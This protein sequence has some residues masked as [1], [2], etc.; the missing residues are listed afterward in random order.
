MIS[1]PSIKEPNH[2]KNNSLIKS[3]DYFNV[4]P[5]K[6]HYNYFSIKI[7][8]SSLEKLSS[9]NDERY[10]YFLHYCYIRRIE[11]NGDI[12]Y[13]E[14][15]QMPKNIIIYRKPSVRNKNNGKLYLNQKDLPHI[16]LFEGEES[17]KLLSLESN[18]ITKIEHL[19]SLNNLLFLNLYDNQITEIDNLQCVPKLRCLM[20][21]KNLIAKIKNLSCVPE[22][23]I[24]DLHNNKIKQIE[25]LVFLQKL[26][27]L[28][29]SNNQLNTFIQLNANKNLE[30]LNLRNNS[31]S[32]IPN[33]NNSFNKLKKLNLSKNIIS[34]MEYILELKKL[35]KLEELYL[36]GNGVIILK[37]FYK[38]IS[39]LP[40]KYNEKNKNGIISL[41]N[42]GYNTAYIDRNRKTN[43]EIVN[44]I[45]CNLITSPSPNKKNNIFLSNDSYTNN[46]NKRNHNISALT[47]NIF[48][49][50]KSFNRTNLLIHTNDNKNMNAENIS[51]SG[52]KKIFKIPS[53]YFKKNIVPQNVLYTDSYSKNTKNNNNNY[54]NESLKS[55]NNLNIKILGRVYS[56][57]KMDEEKQNEINQMIDK[58]ITI[59]NIKKEW[60]REFQYI[61]KNGLNGY[62]NKKL[63]ET[64]IKSY[65]VEL[66]QNKKLN[67]FGNGL[68]EL[69]NKSYYQVITSI[70]FSFMNIDLILRKKYMNKIIKFLDLRCLIFDNNNFNSCYQLLKLECLENLQKIIIINNEVCNGDLIK[71]FLIYRIPNIKYINN[72][73]INNKDIL[74]CKNMFKLFDDLICVCETT[75][76]KK[77]KET[78]IEPVNIEN[79]NENNVEVKRKENEKQKLYTEL[80]DKNK[81]FNF[82][83]INLRDVLEDILSNY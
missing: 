42:L 21:G 51:Y 26:R 82:V 50:K 6:E 32:I 12:L 38:K 46:F 62:V 25:N 69:N 22:I 65:Y 2:K 43:N 5:R 78:E 74:I 59:N 19:I 28:N 70:Q 80:N 67:I 66:E 15:P 8:N 24:L 53:D 61:L 16:P 57:R 76:K 9:E 34:K 48:S 14:I 68:E 39:G 47:N 55:N 63:K 23:Q 31:I 81:Y 1:L 83:K 18:H 49:I 27:I 52:P 35:K 17:L 13:I 11:N 36:E 75:N 44:N 79:I 30:E 37:D 73:V 4:I 77:E 40:L 56:L 7:H 64:K 10:S 33:L 41:S 60:E 20:L 54:L 58:D 3:L 72:N 45:N 29:I 71:Y